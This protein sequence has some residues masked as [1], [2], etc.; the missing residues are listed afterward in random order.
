MDLWNL[1]ILGFDQSFLVQDNLLGTL[2]FRYISF[3]T[4]KAS[5]N[6][7]FLVLLLLIFVVQKGSGSFF[8]T[9]IDPEKSLINILSWLDSSSGMFLS[10]YFLYRYSSSS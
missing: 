6:L 5:Q 1:D 7:V 2:L 8:C 4:S 9:T 10:E 3:C